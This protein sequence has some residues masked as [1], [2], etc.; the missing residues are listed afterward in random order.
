MM[1]KESNKLMRGDVKIL[2]VQRCVCRPCGA[3]LH[4]RVC[5]C[6]ARAAIK[7]LCQTTVYLISVCFMLHGNCDQLSPL[8][9]FSS[10]VQLLTAPQLATVL[11]VG[12]FRA[13]AAPWGTVCR[14]LATKWHSSMNVLPTSFSSVWLFRG[15]AIR[16]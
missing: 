4:S 14:E 13:R 11:G 10:S 5:N 16:W 12:L 8:C 15:A 3:L 2:P 1:N 7:K 6:T 9:F